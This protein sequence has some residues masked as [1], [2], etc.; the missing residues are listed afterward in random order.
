MDF[1]I[2]ALKYW[3]LKPPFC[4]NRH[5]LNAGGHFTMST[6]R[7]ALA[8]IL[9]LSLMSVLA[10]SHAFPTGLGPTNHSIKHTVQSELAKLDVE[11]MFAAD[12]LSRTGLSGAEARNILN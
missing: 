5:R 9:A 7:F 2:L 3:S 11:L 1:E 10:C 4:Y 6:K 8:I 12:R